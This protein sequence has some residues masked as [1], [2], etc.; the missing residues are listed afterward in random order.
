MS[1]DR[2]PAAPAPGRAADRI[3]D[4]ARRLFYR[5]GI[6]AVGV[7][8]IVAA[9]GVTKPSLYRAFASK[10]D[11]AVAYLCDYDVAF[12][13]SFEALVAPFAGDPR[14]QILAYFDNRGARALMPGY[15]GCGLTNAVLEYPQAGHPTHAVALANKRRLR[16]RLRGMAREMGAARPEALGDGLLL[17]ME[18]MFAT[19]QLFGA[20]GPAG[21]ITAIAATLID[22][23]LTEAAAGG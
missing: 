15:R 7:E 22:A 21:S 1:Q 4:T 19:G 16:E 11:L 20:E 3:R 2:Q 23:H 6:R 18:G 14:R 10:D 17:L 8:E 5:Q 9:A 13:E 12:W